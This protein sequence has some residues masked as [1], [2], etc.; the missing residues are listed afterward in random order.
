MVGARQAMETATVL[1]T[2]NRPWHTS[3]VLESLSKNTVLPD[4]LYIFHDGK[5]DTTV[6]SDWNKVESI[7][8]AVDWCDCEVITSEINKG[9]ADSVVFGINYVL[10]NYTSVIVLEDD[11]VLAADFVN[12]MMQCFEKY[13]NDEKVFAVSGYGFP[14]SCKRKKYDVYGCGRASSWGWG[15]W[16][17]RWKIFNKDYESIRRMK[18][19]EDMSR[20]LAMW[21]ND[22]EDMV[23]GN[24]RGIIDSWA[25]FWALN[26]ISRKGICINPYQSLIKNIGCDGSGTHC[27]NSHQYDVQISKVKR[28]KF[29][30]PDKLI[31][32]SEIIEALTPLFGSYTAINQ[33]SELKETI[34]VY[35]LGNFFCKK[36]Q[37][38]NSKYYIEAFIDQRKKGWYA[39]K[40]IVCMDDIKKYA[41]DKII[42]MIQDRQECMKVEQQLL[43]KEIDQKKILIG[44]NFFE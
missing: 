44:H 18:Q 23:V 34:L 20:N 29:K 10:K 5:K 38:L 14:I 12:F 27:G 17:D 15:T 8:R 25:I 19:E 21:G 16:A 36:E 22:L 37:E 1:F 41:Y 40:R 28:K 13:K 3:K 30:L 4:K 26:I 39:G 35:G 7:I 24:V 32:S 31:F 43:Q 2:Y 11:C 9:L 6:I 33:R 42:I